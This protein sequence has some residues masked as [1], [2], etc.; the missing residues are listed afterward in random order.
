MERGRPDDT[1]DPDDFATIICDAIKAALAP[2]AAR[3]K[4]AGDAVPDLRSELRT[5]QQPS[6]EWAG[7]WKRETTFH[8]GQLAT[9]RGALWLAKCST[10]TRP[11]EDAYQ[12]VLIVKSGSFSSVRG[13]A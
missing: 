1:L 2:I 5:K 11:G 4:A 8:R 9:D 3:L 6:C 12:W 7:T 10:T 13:V